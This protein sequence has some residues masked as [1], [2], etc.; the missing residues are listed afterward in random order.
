MNPELNELNEREK[1][2]WYIVRSGKLATLRLS[3]SS[4]FQE[5]A[6]SI[7]ETNKPGVK[8]ELN[9]YLAQLYFDDLCGTEIINRLVSMPFSKGKLKLNLPRELQ[10]GLDHKI[11]TWEIRRDHYSFFL[12]NCAKS[13]K[14]FLKIIYLFF[15]LT[16][17][18]RLS[19]PKSKKNVIFVINHTKEFLIQK[20]TKQFQEI[21]N[22]SQWRSV[23]GLKIKDVTFIREINFFKLLLKE[24]T[25]IENLSIF[26]KV[27]SLFPKVLFE[28][29]VKIRDVFIASEQIMLYLIVRMSKPSSFYF[30]IGFTE[31]SG[32]KRPLWTYELEKLGVPIT[33]IMFSNSAVLRVH[34][35]EA[36]PAEFVRYSWKDYEL[37]SDWQ[38]KLLRKYSIFGLESKFR[39]NGVPWYQDRPYKFLQSD[40]CVIAVFDVEPHLGYFGITSLNDWELSSISYA[41]DFL[42]SIMEICAKH[43]VLVM[44]KRKRDLPKGRIHP[45]YA[46]KLESLAKNLHYLR[47]PAYVAPS[48]LIQQVS[49]VISSIPTTTELL[50]RQMNI[51]SIYFDP[52]GKINRFDPVLVESI[53][54]SS[55]EELEKWIINVKSSSNQ[56]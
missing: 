15:M 22:Y 26:V 46:Q 55:Q 45:K 14:S 12:W 42:D 36:Y 16:T 38:H 30:E 47:I 33:M 25:Y 31:S 11:P 13:L 43:E 4:V 54:L 34:N 5:L 3:L 9:L 23:K 29:G 48:K 49:G 41:L 8:R 10:E 32:S 18:F 1:R 40:K 35:E 56:A 53:I 19:Y 44:H 52:S 39:I 50:A 37:V 27:I 51:P 17:R 2:Y 20:S 7:L 24:N 21:H 28:S 6:T